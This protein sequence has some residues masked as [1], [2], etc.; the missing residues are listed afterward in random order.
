MFLIRSD[1]DIMRSNSGLVLIWIIESLDIFKVTYVKSCN[2]VCSGK[3]EIEESAILADVGA[4]IERK[5]VKMP[6][7]AE[8]A[9]EHILDSNCVA[10]LGTKVIQLFDN[11]LF[12]VCI[13]SV[14][15]DDPNLP[16]M[17]SSGE[18]S[19]FR[20]ARDELHILDSTSLKE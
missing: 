2:V 10:S 17:H 14:R 3:G 6:H 13:L 20:V 8:R 12:A 1:L 7:Y 19:A 11:T 9:D 16:K 5:V 4:V 15:V 18:S